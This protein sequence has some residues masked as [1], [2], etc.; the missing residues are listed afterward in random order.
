[1]LKVLMQ[2]KEWDDHKASKALGGRRTIRGVFILPAEG[3][4][5]DADETCQPPAYGVLHRR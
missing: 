3:I 4:A 1:M 2:A 5:C